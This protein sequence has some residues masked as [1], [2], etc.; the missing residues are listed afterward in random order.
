MEPGDND[1]R[2]GL[3][4]DFYIKSPAASAAP[5]AWPTASASTEH[6]ED[7]FEDY[8]SVRQSQSHDVSAAVRAAPEGSHANQSRPEIPETSRAA[9]P[10]GEAQEAGLMS[11]PA[12]SALAPHPSESPLAPSPSSASMR[13][14]TGSTAQR[15]LRFDNPMHPSP[16]GSRMQIDPA[17][18]LSFG[19][20]SEI[21]ASLDLGTDSES[22]E[23]NKQRF[24]ERLEARW[25]ESGDLEP[26]DYSVLNQLQASASASLDAS[27]S[28]P[29]AQLLQTLAQQLRS[30]AESTSGPTSGAP[31]QEPAERAESRRGGEQRRADEQPHAAAQG[32]LA[33][34]NGLG[35][36]VINQVMSVTN[37]PASAGR[38]GAS[39][40]PSLSPRPGSARAARPP[41]G[42]LSLSQEDLNS[43][44]LELQQQM[45]GLPLGGEARN[46]Q[47]A[48]AHREAELQKQLDA[49]RAK[50]LAETEARHAAGQKLA[51]QKREQERAEKR[52]REH[53]EARLREKQKELS[54][55]RARLQ[56]VEGEEPR[57]K[58]LA[59]DTEVV[60]TG[61]ELAALRR[62]IT[63]QEVLLKGYQAEN[64]AAVERMREMA[65]EARRAEEQV[66]KEH[67]HMERTLA[68][69]QEQSQHAH[70][71]T[72]GKLAAVLQL[73]AAL[74][75]ARQD[76]TSREAEL[77]AEMERLRREKKEAEAR[78]GG[79]NLPQMEA[80]DSVVKRMA[81]DKEA[82][83]QQ[84]R[85]EMQGMMQRHAE[86]A[87][88]MEAKLQ[89]YAENQDLVNQNSELIRQQAE[90]IAQM[91]QQLVQYESAGSKP[92]ATARKRIKELEAEVQALKD[93]LTQRHPNSIPA[94]IAA[95]KPSLEDS[96]LVADLRSKLQ[97][98][99]AALVLK[100]E[101]ME[102]ELRAL[103]QEQERLKRQFQGHNALSENGANKEGRSARAKEL[104][105]QL[106]E[107]RAMYTRKLRAAEAKLQDVLKAQRESAAEP[108]AAAPSKDA[109]PA[110]IQ[111]LKLREQKIK[112]LEGDLAFK[113]GVVR[114]L[115]KRLH[116]LEQD[117]KAAR[118][119]ADAPAASGP[120]PTSA[121]DEEAIAALQ[122]VAEELASEND[123]LRAQL[124][125]VTAHQSQQA[126]AELAKLREE[127]DSL[128]QRLAAAEMAMQTV[129]RAHTEA[130][131]R[132]T[133]LQADHQRQMSRLYEEHAGRV[134]EVAK[135]AAA[136][137]SVR[138]R[139][140]VEAAEK[141]RG[142]A[143]QQAALLQEQLRSA[144]A[145]VPWSPKAAEFAA[146]ERKILDMEAAEAQR[147]AQWG[148]LL[149][150]RRWLA[151]A[152]PAPEPSGYPHDPA[153]DMQS[154]EIER[155]RRELDAI[156][157]S[158]TV[159]QQQQQQQQHLQP[160]V[161][162]E[163]QA[164]GPAYPAS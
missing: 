71:E 2:R 100:D 153:L 44:F 36:S 91:E 43:K 109:P 70:A 115:E 151:A 88:Q 60:L 3:A 47:R 37:T 141:A 52:L 128:R 136:D 90:T 134:G 19:R 80:E 30:P 97:R 50:L 102:N 13:L 103:R 69:M 14:V 72:G 48:G 155:L 121:D 133:L 85:G 6:Y 152:L 132:S 150:E 40:S 25:R 146:L 139:E 76:A 145:N 39:A 129:Q 123:A 64:E 23:V 135:R 154:A 82:Q 42:P 73:E 124:E 111:Q 54:S 21:K 159:L 89:W 46:Q 56:E 20:L 49:L 99:Q 118:R 32:S 160:G 143:A 15:T 33:S 63:E 164:Q 34:L 35:S 9:A 138:W 74:E 62:E 31:S 108:K 148:S 142:E 96:A 116:A 65:A 81:A 77:R 104:E 86:M 106:E 17:Q 8:E 18:L 22:E 131:E 66:A 26:L 93:A 126:P 24:F 1:E 7:D 157:T 92:G 41:H 156:L 98:L 149:E 28:S 38:E 117:L 163:P 127:A 120:S 158:A 107:V 5:R 84:I 53:Y 137:E 68:R 59:A 61:S 114:E 122:Q 140:R 57:A 105:K 101:E 67:A 29:G 110:H 4:R 119:N 130:V 87:A 58:V 144:R 45:Q 113:D 78:A 79:L 83:L 16:V 125:A 162:Q 51:E 55:T 161:M 27:V 12:A 112:H 10:A 11:P 147:A 95:A 94:L 75:A